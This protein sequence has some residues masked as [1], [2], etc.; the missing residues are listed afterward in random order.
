MSD[1]SRKLALRARRAQRRLGAVEGAVRTRLLETLAERLLSEWERIAAAN[2]QDVAEAV[3]QG[4]P[5]AIVQR[6]GLSAKKRVELL[7]GLGDLAAQED[8]LGVPLRRTEL[9]DGLVL[10]QI[11]CPLGV[12]LVIFESRPDAII[13]I[14]SLA[15]RTANA[16]LLK[17]GREARRSN[18]ALIDC[19]RDTLQSE[20]LDADAV[21][22]VESRDLAAELLQEDD[23]IDLVIPRGSTELVRSIQ[24]QTS[25]HVLGHAAGVCHLYVDRDADPDMASRL[26][27]DGKCSYPS[28]CNA[29][30]ALLIHADFLPRSGPMLEALARN[31]V[32]LR[33]DD[34]AAKMAPEARLADDAD[35]G[36]EYGDLRIAVHVVDSIDEAMDFIARHGS[37]HTDAICTND[38]HAAATF[39]NAVDSASVL[40]NASTRFADGYRYGLGAEV[41]IST[42]RIHARGPVGSEG[43]MSSRWL[44]RGCGQIVADYGAGGRQFVHRRLP[45]P[46]A[47]VGEQ[48]SGGKKLQAK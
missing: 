43:L 34:R 8:A 33:V 26:A 28:A 40:H 11:R 4:L 37:S 15:L 1:L 42:A 21:I 36:K 13:Q 48:R 24:K 32:E 30:E 22:N 16:V 7:S 10:E 31:G 19:M 23:L 17:G 18:A 47:A 39:L 25:I 20:G 46:S 44:L 14:G 38:V 45:L 29:T 27:V 3:Q 5:D 12:I 41:G 35:L 9:D 2:E 6:L